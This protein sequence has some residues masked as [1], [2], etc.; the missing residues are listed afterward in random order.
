MWRHHL[1]PLG[2]LGRLWDE[3]LMV[4]MTGTHGLVSV[5]HVSVHYLHQSG[6]LDAVW[7]DNTHEHAITMSNMQ[8]PRPCL[9]LSVLVRAVPGLCLKVKSDVDG[10]P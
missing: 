10:Y 9:C 5:R 7:G 8:R 4:S 3:T 2:R 1:H 6:Q